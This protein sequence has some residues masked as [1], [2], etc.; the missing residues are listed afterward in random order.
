MT[1]G[2]SLAPMIATLDAMVG[3]ARKL[4]DRSGRGADSRAADEMMYAAEHLRDADRLLAP[5]RTEEA[6]AEAKA[7]KRS[8]FR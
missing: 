4:A 8:A 7:A 6:Q 5:A 1:V 2:A 3:T